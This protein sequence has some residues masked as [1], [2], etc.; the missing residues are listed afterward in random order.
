V[1]IPPS[2]VNGE[3][4]TWNYELANGRFADL[5]TLTSPFTGFVFEGCKDNG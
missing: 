2:I 4:Y 5:T 1:V 3:K